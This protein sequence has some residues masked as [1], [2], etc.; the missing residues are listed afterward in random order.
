MDGHRC[1][2]TMWSPW[3]TPGSASNLLCASDKASHL[4]TC[5]SSSCTLRRCERMIPGPAFT[6]LS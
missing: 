2:V 6:S 5:R 4:R 3:L 1:E